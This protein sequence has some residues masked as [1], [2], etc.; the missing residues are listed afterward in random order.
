MK[1][2]FPLFVI[3]LAAAPA[4][5]VPDGA[6]YVNDISSPDNRGNMIQLRRYVAEVRGGKVSL[7][8]WANPQWFPPGGF[9]PIVTGTLNGLVAEMPIKGGP[10]TRATFTL[11][12]DE[13]WADLAYYNG[14]GQVISTDKFHRE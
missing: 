11:S 13:L 9:E 7:Q 12:A 10:V 2:W 8:R 6:K 1:K 3:M 5:A 14:S 4:F